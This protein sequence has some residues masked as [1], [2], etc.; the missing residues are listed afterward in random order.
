MPPQWLAV[1]TI[2]EGM[3]YM[4]QDY[5]LRDWM[6]FV[7]DEEPELQD[8]L[9]NPI[10]VPTIDDQSDMH[11][12]NRTTLTLPFGTSYQWSAETTALH[13]AST[14]GDTS[15]ESLLIDDVPTS[16]D[17]SVEGFFSEHS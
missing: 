8:P 4:I 9:E 12:D 6:Q 10:V 3:L 11:S 16:G 5:T 13:G 1:E 15:T 2:P 17:P 7:G 14:F